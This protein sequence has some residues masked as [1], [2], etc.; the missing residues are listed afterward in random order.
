MFTKVLV[1]TDLSGAS[2]QVIG[3]IGDLSKSARARRC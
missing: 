2:E 1:A 3:A